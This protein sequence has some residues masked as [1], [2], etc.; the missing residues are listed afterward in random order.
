M[1][2]RCSIIHVRRADVI[3]ENQGRK[4]YNVSEYIAK[5]PKDR[6]E[7]GANILLLTDDANAIVMVQL[8]RTTTKESNSPR[9]LRKLAV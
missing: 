4:F 1:H 6:R 2:G 7:P 3:I 8:F 9:Y 5:L